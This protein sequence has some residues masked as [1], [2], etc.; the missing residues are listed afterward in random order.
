LK[1]SFTPRECRNRFHW[2]LRRKKNCRFGLRRATLRHVFGAKT[3]LEK[4]NAGCNPRDAPAQGI[5]AS[6]T[7]TSTDALPLRIVGPTTVA[8]PI[9]G[10]NQLN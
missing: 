5:A 7:R 3:R 6:A 1:K 9:W 4:M 8:P 10:S 2:L